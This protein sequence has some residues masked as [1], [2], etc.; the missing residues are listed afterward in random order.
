MAR[1]LRAAYRTV[2]DDHF[3]AE[4]TITFGDTTLRYRKRTWVT[5][6]GEEA[7]RRGLRYGDNPGQEA[8]LYELV[9]GNLILGGC[10]F[11]GPGL[12]L[13]SA[14]SEE[15][16]LQA[17]KHPGKTNL[18]DIDNALNILKFL[19]QR[20][21]CLIMKH[22]NPSGAAEAGSVFE[23]F[24][25][26]WRADPIAAFGGCVVANRTLD[27]DTARALAERYVEVVAAPEFAPGAV[28]L[29]KGRRNLRIV[30]IA[31]ID[32]L[33]DYRDRRVVEFKSLADGGLIV[34]QSPLN[35]I[36]TREDFRPAEQ[37]RKGGEVVRAERAPTG[38]EY[39]DMVFGWAVEQGVASNS[40]LYVRDGCTVGVCAGE[41]DRVGAARIAL[42]KAVSKY[43]EALALERYGVPMF[44]LEGQAARGERDAAAARELI[45]ES[46][47]VR[48]GVR[49]SVMISDAFFPEPD[50]VM[51][52]I[53][54]G[55]SAVCHPG[56]SL[57][58]WAGVEAC[59][60]ADPQVAMVFTGQRA[61]KH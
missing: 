48:G 39:D 3:P 57:K 28:D 29:L 26:A 54:A 41:Q 47:A 18:T 35:A 40:V 53:E 49:G 21:A 9:G 45:E 36:R 31:R 17:G 32:R 8:A 51:V 11:I 23:A 25:R 12:G 27:L 13:V 37:K 7:A 15:D 33:A 52:G 59:N 44:E 38:A 2:T 6:E 60:R 14:L 61:F 24:S 10:E 4:M 5:G 46:E 30:R 34:Q 43:A 1:S 56:G 50:G 55:V 58:D 20:P 19:T 22:N 16:L 42:A